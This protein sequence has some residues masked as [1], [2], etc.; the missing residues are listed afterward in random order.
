M[1]NTVSNRQAGFTL[2]ELLVVVAII[3]IVTTLLTINLS[4][5]LNTSN[6]ESEAKRLM[7]KI[8]GL[9]DQAMISQSHLGLVV[10]QKEILIYQQQEDEWQALS[11][12]QPSSIQVSEGVEL[13]APVQA[14]PPVTAKD[15]PVQP[16]ITLHLGTD[17]RMTAYRLGIEDGETR[18]YLVM[19]RAGGIQVDDCERY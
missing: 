10:K 3:G 17:G 14:P 1:Y 6:T 2:I 12:P 7:I 16:S 8:H 11:A 9:L 13:L 15:E 18:C 19:N 5:W 4:T